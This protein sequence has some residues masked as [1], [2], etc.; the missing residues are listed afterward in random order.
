MAAVVPTLAMAHAADARTG[1]GHGRSPCFS[2]TLLAPAADCCVSSPHLPLPTWCRDLADAAY[3][4]WQPTRR[5]SLP[6]QDDFVPLYGTGLRHVPSFAA[7][8]ALH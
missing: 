8:S 3:A 2:I 1:T 7:A 5:S 6:G 4:A